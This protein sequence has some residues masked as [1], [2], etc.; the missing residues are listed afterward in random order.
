MYM[1]PSAINVNK[2]Q[3]VIMLLSPYV[4]NVFI[5]QGD[6]DKQLFWYYTQTFTNRNA[7]DR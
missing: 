4:K 6:D 5:T 1:T 3:I 2:T 7:I